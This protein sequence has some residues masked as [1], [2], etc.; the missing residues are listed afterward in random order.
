MNNKKKLLAVQRSKPDPLSREPGL[1]RDVERLNTVSHN[2]VRSPFP[3]PSCTMCHFFP[4]L[5]ALPVMDA[6]RDIAGSWLDPF[7]LALQRSVCIPVC[8]HDCPEMFCS[9]TELGQYSLTALLCIQV[10]SCCSAGA[11]SMQQV[12]YMLR[13]RRMVPAGTEGG[14][15]PQGAVGGHDEA[16]V[17]RGALARTAV[18]GEQQPGT[19]AKFDRMRV[20]EVPRQAD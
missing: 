8:A 5:P 10:P 3:A 13:S 7:R 14:C 19:A 18:A 17:Q 16:C 2:L 11:G 1:R 9:G 12:F 20:A 4:V 15:G 6:G